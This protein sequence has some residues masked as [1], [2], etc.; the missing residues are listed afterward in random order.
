VFLSFFELKFAFVSSFFLFC[1]KFVSNVS[2]FSSMS[3][4]DTVFVICVFIL[5]I[6]VFVYCFVLLKSLF[7]FVV[8]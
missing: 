2:G 3:F 8:L 6:L 4:F 5:P 1:S 7:L